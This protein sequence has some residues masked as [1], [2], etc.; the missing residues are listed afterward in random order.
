MRYNHHVNAT[1]NLIPILNS[2]KQVLRRPQYLILI[3]TITGT[4]L[5]FAIWLPN[6]HLLTSTFHSDVLSLAQKTNLSFSLLGGLATNFTPLSRVI[7]ITI[8]LLF[9]LNVAL[10]VFYFR[11]RLTLGRETGASLGGLILGL[12]GVGCASCGSV[13][14]TTLLG[15]SVSASVLG[16][17]PL[18]G[19]EFGLLGI[20]FLLF[21][22][23]SIARKL[24]FP[25][26]CIIKPAE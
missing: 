11:T 26:N 25:P 16:L 21:S 12:L 18:K 4:L 5:A 7:T 10:A 22:I 6:L 8:S 1:T 20:A 14:I 24:A 23:I 15:L 17:F 13:V 3:T 19:Q 2:I 9:G